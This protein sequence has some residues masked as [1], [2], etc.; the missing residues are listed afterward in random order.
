[1]EVA[2]S[3]GM[4]TRIDARLFDDHAYYDSLSNKYINQISSGEVAQEVF[5]MA[6]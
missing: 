1:M 5:F 4:L 3:P 6:V 2:V